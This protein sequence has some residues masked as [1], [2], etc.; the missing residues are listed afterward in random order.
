MIKCINNA[1]DSGSTN[2]IYHD[3]MCGSNVNK[4][5]VLTGRGGVFQSVAGRSV[6]IVLLIL[7]QIVSSILSE[8]I[9]LW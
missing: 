2:T 5:V 3:V 4:Y 7:F 9:P 1:D 6:I 8:D